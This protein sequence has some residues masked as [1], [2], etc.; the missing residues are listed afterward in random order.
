M[1]RTSF[2]TF[3]CFLFGLTYSSTNVIG[4]AISRFQ[5]G[6]ASF[7]KIWPL[8]SMVLTL[9]ASAGSAIWG[10]CISAVG[11]SVTLWAILAVMAVNLALG[12]AC[13]RGKSDL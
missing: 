10:G 2:V 1:S 7:E 12:L 3:A 11:Y 5:F 4:P 6:A 13:V 9:I 8:V